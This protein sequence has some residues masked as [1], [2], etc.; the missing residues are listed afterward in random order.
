VSNFELDELQSVEYP[1]KWGF[2]FE[3]SVVSWHMGRI[4]ESIKLSTH[5]LENVTMDEDYTQSVKGNVKAVWGTIDYTKPSYYTKKDKDKLRYKFNGIDVIDKNYS[6]AFQDIFILMALDGKQNGK[7]LEIG[8]NKPF[9]HSNTYLLEDKFNWQGVSLELNPSLVTWFNGKRKNKCLNRDATKADYL[10]ILDNENLG[11]EWDYLQSD[12]EPAR[13]TFESL[14]LIPFE[15]YKFAVITYEHDWYIDED[16]T[17]RDKSR[18]YLKMMGYE[19]V[20]TNISV[21]DK[22]PFEDWWVHPELVNPK[23]I[24]LLKDNSEINSVKSYIFN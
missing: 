11:T 8:A 3:K 18:K 4:D 15:K 24:K 1:G 16:K 22:S 12:C 6:Q 9:E 23:I 14:L 10:Q 7:Y 20:V 2:L 5:L 17:I 13:N 21:D 19:L